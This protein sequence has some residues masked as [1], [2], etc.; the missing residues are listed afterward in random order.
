[1]AWTDAAR[2]AA[3]AARMAHADK[4]F[5]IAKTKNP[6]IAAGMLNAATS[7][8]SLQHK[9]ALTFVMKSGKKK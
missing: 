5:S 2:A 8:M 7:K 9:V 1:M 4:M 6:R 3:K